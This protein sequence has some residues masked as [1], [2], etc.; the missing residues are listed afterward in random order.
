MSNNKASRLTSKIFPKN[1]DGL[2]TPELEIEAITAPAYS[3][4]GVMMF[5]KSTMGEWRPQHYNQKY[6][7]CICIRFVQ[8]SPRIASEMLKLNIENNRAL[9]EADVKNYSAQMKNEQWWWQAMTP[10]RFSDEG[11]LLDGQHRLNA[12]LDSGKT[13]PTLVVYNV[14]T[15]AVRGI[16]TG[17]KRTPAQQVTLQ[18]RFT[19]NE[20]ITIAKLMLASWSNFKEALTAQQL[21]VVL[22]DAMFEDAMKFAMDSIPAVKGFIAAPVQAVVAKA[23]LM[24]KAGLDSS[25]ISGKAAS[26]GLRR[27]KE[28]CNQMTAAGKIIVQLSKAEM[29]SAATGKQLEDAGVSESVIKLAQFLIQGKRADSH[30]LEKHKKTT[31]VLRRF[32]DDET[33]ERVN[34]ASEDYW[35]DVRSLYY[36][37]QSQPQSQPQQV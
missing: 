13:E 15:A 35:G 12:I 23:V 14:P 36:V 26:D 25:V 29:Q 1:K 21:E 37:K 28:F 10:I 3:D 16:D 33:F 27:I 19:R 11:R 24:V 9:S 6:K 4:G 18:G 32:I 30:G 17:K 22:K 7:N 2:K 5:A 34:E 31:W 20:E 8:I